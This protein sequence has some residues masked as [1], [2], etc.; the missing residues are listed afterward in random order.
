[1][2]HSFSLNGYLLQLIFCCIFEVLFEILLFLELPLRGAWVAQLVKH[3]PWAQVIVPESWDPAL[4]W[5]P[6]SAGSLLLPLPLQLPLLI[7]SLSLSH[8]LSV[9]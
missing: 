5:A 3:L 8:V 6:C 9:K 1:M 2:H 4:H 7:L